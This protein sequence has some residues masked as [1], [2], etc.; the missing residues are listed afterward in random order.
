[1]VIRSEPPDK[2]K[3]EN[4]MKTFNQHAVLVEKTDDVFN[5]QNVFHSNGMNLDGASHYDAQWMKGHFITFHHPS[6]IT[7]AQDIRKLLWNSA[8]LG[9]IEY[10]GE[11]EVTDEELSIQRYAMQHDI[12]YQ[13]AKKLF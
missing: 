7:E 5:L 6:K 13:A 11:A 3:K 12:S 4:Y 2:I 9:K 1:M 10:C 8:F